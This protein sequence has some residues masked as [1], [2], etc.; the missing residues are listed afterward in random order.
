MFSLLCRSG[1]G[2]SNSE[3]R[4]MFNQSGIKTTDKKMTFKMEDIA[5]PG[6]VRV[7]KRI[8]VR[9]VA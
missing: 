5:I 3:I 1:L 8:L 4:R 6:D 9:I 2:I 7:G